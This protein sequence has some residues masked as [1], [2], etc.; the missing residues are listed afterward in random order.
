[1]GPGCA[2][3]SHSGAERAPMLG[4]GFSAWRAHAPLRRRDPLEVVARRERAGRCQS[5]AMAG[6]WM[7]KM[8]GQVLQNAQAPE[9]RH[10]KRWVGKV[11]SADVLVLDTAGPLW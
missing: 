5:Q 4:T 11:S 10:G 2:A 3:R 9:P 1:M 8:Q 6:R 7:S